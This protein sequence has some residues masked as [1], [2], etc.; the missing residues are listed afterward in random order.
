[1]IDQA[2]TELNQGT[3]VLDAAPTADL[4][5]DWA[6]Y[7][8]NQETSIPVLESGLTQIGAIQ[9]GES[10]ADQTFL[11]NADEHLVTAAQNI[12]T[13]DQGIVAADQAGDLSGNLASNP[14]DLPLIDADFALFTAD[15]TALGDT[16]LAGFFPDVG[17]L[18]P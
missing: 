5:T 14:A 3:A 18:L 8:S 10:A 1:M 17:T 9:E 15:F 16:I 13:A 11:A 2:V 7:L 4:G 6:Q 12:L